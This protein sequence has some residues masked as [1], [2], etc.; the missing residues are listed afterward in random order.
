MKQPQVDRANWLKYRWLVFLLGIFLLVIGQSRFNNLEVPDAPPTKPAVWLNEVLHLGIHGVDNILSALPYL[1][2]GGVLLAISLRGISLV[3]A[4]PVAIGQSRVEVRYLLSRWPWL[5]VGSITFV[6]LILRINSADYFPFQIP[7]W[8]ASL[9]ILAFVMGEWDRKREVD[10][11]PHLSRT[12]WIWLTGLM[13]VGIL[14]GVYRLEGFPD[15][16][17]GDEGSFWTIARDIA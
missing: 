14:V 17:M 5:L 13:G 4:H 6:L 2:V 3:P 10:L 11:S 12:D 8:L 16:L 1:F 7:F 15:Q 9:F